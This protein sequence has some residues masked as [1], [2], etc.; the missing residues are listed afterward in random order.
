MFINW[1]PQNQVLDTLLIISIFVAMGF[2]LIFDSVKLLFD[3]IT[4]LKRP[5]IVITKNITLCVLLIIFL[6]FPVLL[7]FL[8]YEKADASG[9]EDIY[10][11][12]DRIFNTIEDSSSI[13]ASSTSANIGKYMSLV[14][15]PEK[16]VKFILN[17]D[18]EY[19][20]DNILNDIAE[21]RNVY[22]VNAEDF[23]TESL[24][25]EAL[26]DFLWKRFNDE[27]YKEAIV[28][29]RIIGEKVIPEIEY[30]IEKDK[31][32]FGEQFTLEYNII[33]DNPVGIEVT[34]LELDLPD[35]VAFENITDL[36]M[37]KDEPSISQGKYMWVEDYF[38]DSG[39][40]MS[41]EMMLRAAR[42]GKAEILFRITS[43]N[44]YFDAEDIDVEVVE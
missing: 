29:F 13:Y 18:K 12:W 25:Y 9:V 21:G 3:R 38:I 27:R 31:V 26:F 7:G 5:R 35:S 34:S 8:N 11:F 22:L 4:A 6:T 30:V 42:P 40:K 2:L 24:N 1:A 16:K 15:R 23:L 17:R 20:V 44:S 32:G 43:Q 36:S 41:L 39:D 10:L 37:I 28:F 19:T 33:N 14:E